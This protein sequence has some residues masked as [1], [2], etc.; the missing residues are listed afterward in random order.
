MIAFPEIKVNRIAIKLSTASE[1]M[2]KKGHPWIFEKGIIKESPGA[3][4]GDLAI[5]FDEKKN[6][7]LAI[8]L[9]DPYSP[10]RIKLL[11]FHTKAEIGKA[12]FDEKI[13][14]A[15]EKRKSLFETKTNSYRLIFGENDLFPGLIVDKYNHVIVVK[16]YSHIWFPYLADIIPILKEIAQADCGVLRLSRNLMTTRDTFGLEN[17]SY[18]FGKLEDENILFEEHGVKFKA[19]VIHGHKTGFFLDHRE[20]RRLVGTMSKGK[21]V[22]DVF[23]YAGGFS[24]HALVGGAAHVTSLDISPHALKLASANVELNQDRVVGKHHTI[25]RDAFEVLQEFVRNNKKFDLV[26]IDPPS[27][28]KSAKEISGAINSYARLAKL[29]IKLTKSSGVLLLA[30]CSS[31]ISADDFFAINEEVIKNENSKLKLQRKSF[32]DVDHPIGFAEGSYLKAG[33]YSVGNI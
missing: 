32:H 7:F 4:A 17:G 28:A 11:Q 10:I 2:V 20:N 8:G 27:F 30:S 15:Y 26:I 16:L 24:V 25:A 22:L 14:Q 19:N 23:S 13:K 9:Y 33:Y 12:W 1:R 31:R 6:K 5:I 21:E 18:L 29:G 3:K